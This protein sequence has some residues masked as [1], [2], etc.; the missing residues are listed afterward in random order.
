LDENDYL[1]N[2]TKKNEYVSGEERKKPK[3]G[4]G[5]ESEEHKEYRIGAVSKTMNKLWWTHLTGH[6]LG[7]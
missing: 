5:F 6:F 2:G 3:C 4:R 1:F 7:V